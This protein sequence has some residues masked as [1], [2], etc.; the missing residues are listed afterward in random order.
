MLRMSHPSAHEHLVCVEIGRL[1]RL[2]DPAVGKDFAAVIEEHD[3]VAQKAP[4]LVR[5]SADDM[6]PFAICLI[7]GR[8][9][10]LVLAHDRPRWSGWE[11]AG[12]RSDS[13]RVALNTG[14]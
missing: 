9:V 4:P 7:G 12:C 1:A 8:A 11:A 14:P 10:R 5:V 13:S 3:T 6:G 2:D